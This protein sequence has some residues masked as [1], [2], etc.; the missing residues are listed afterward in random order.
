MKQIFELLKKDIELAKHEV[1]RLYEVSKFKLTNNLLI[2]DTNKDY[3]LNIS[4]SKAVYE[5]LFECDLN[6]LKENM[7]SFDWRNAYN[8]SFSLDIKGNINLDKKK[9]AG[10]IWRSVKDPKVDLRQAKTKIIL[11]IN[12]NKVIC[13]KL[14]KIIDKSYLSRKAHKRPSLHPTA[15]DPRLARAC[16]NLAAKPNGNL[17]D[18]F[19]GSGGILIEAGFMGYQTF[20]YDI[21]KNMLKRAKTNLDHYN[22]KSHLELKDA[23]KLNEQFDLIVTD[24]PYGKS[25]RLSDKLLE[26]YKQFL[27]NAYDYTDVIV[28]MFPDFVDYKNLM[29]KWKIKLEFSHYLHKSLSKKI[30]LLEKC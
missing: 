29:S 19:C 3:S 7:S 11:F 28:I 15:L 18:P 13:S 14:I 22:V 16:I 24:L 10:Y 6:D 23:V 27:D 1:L 12:D 20:G 5:Y 30:V 4:Y 9:L 8:D 2:I 21:D 26:L 17:L 25:S